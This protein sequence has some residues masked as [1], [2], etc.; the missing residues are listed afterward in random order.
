MEGPLVILQ[1]K[2]SSIED[3]V[4]DIFVVRHHRP[5]S[6][7]LYEIIIKILY[8]YVLLIVENNNPISS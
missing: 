4:S 7:M 1:W 3:F 5:I 2:N 6:Q 8:K